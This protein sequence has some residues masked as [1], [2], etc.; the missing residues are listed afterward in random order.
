M[1][2]L[3]SV[4]AI[5]VAVAMSIA[6]TSDSNKVV[7]NESRA[8]AV[9]RAAV[10]A[11]CGNTA[12]T[13]VSVQENFICNEIGTVGNFNRT[14]TFYRPTPCANPTQPCIQVIQ[15]IGS[16]TVGCNYEVLDVTCGGASTF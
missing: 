5:G 12:L 2:R 11:E 4:L 7:D 13:Q 16:A 8:I 9:A 3:F 1:K 6:F 15:V 14:I 10:N